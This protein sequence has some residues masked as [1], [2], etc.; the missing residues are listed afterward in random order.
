MQFI[1]SQFV[2]L[3]PGIN[4]RIASTL[5]LAICCA[6]LHKDTE[7]IQQLEFQRRHQVTGCVV[8]QEVWLL[9]APYCWQRRAGA[10]GFVRVQQAELGSASKTAARDGTYQQNSRHLQ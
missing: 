8:Q 6:E 9:E 7:V 2:W 3:L 1:L 5:P 4:L 10:G